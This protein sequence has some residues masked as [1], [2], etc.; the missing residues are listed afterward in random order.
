VTTT[1]IYHVFVRGIAEEVW[2][3]VTRPDLTPKYFFGARIE[4]TP[5]TRTTAGPNGE[6]RGHRRG[7]RVRPAADVS[8]AG[9]MWVLSSMKSLVETG[10]GLPRAS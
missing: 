1:Q 7:P 2:E 4:V 9:W 10:E 6:G 3:A 8:G 5:A